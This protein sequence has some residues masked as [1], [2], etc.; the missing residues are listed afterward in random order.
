MLA[1]GF[2]NLLMV[3][4]PHTARGN[5]PQAVTH[6]VEFQAAL[7]RFMQQHNLTR[8]ET[9]PEKVDEWTQIVIKAGEAL[10]SF[11]ADSWQNGVNSNVA[12]R[13]VR[14]VPGYNA[15]ARISG[16]RPTRSPEAA[17]RNSRS[18]SPFHIGLRQRRSSPEIGITYV[19]PS[20][21]QS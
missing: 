19:S 17:A 20:R 3:L 11:K 8:V 18:V 12:G 1:E 4:G 2:P 14:R 9:R 13:T 21:S 10:L 6:S 15:T 7:L 5:I 16:E